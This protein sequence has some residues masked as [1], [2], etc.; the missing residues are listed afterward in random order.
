MRRA[1]PR[2]NGRWRRFAASAA[3]F[4]SVG[5]SP[6]LAQSEQPGLPAL[7]K[8]DEITHDRDLDIVTATGNVEISQGERILRADSISF[9]RRA[10]LVSASGNVSLLEPSGDI[11]FADYI[12]LTDDLKEGIIQDFRAVLA[13]RTRLAAVSA[14]RAD[15][16]ITTARKVVYSPCELCKEDPSRAPLWQLKA[17]RVTHDQETRQITYGDAWM[18]IAGVP[19]FYTPYLS[20]PDGTVKRESGFLAPDIGT[21]SVLGQFTVIPY[22]YAISPSADVTVEPMFLTKDNPV[23]GGEYRQRTAHG[24]FSATASITN[25]KRRDDNNAEIPGNDVRGHLKGEGL[26]D[27]NDDWR[28]GFDVARATDDTYLQ[29]Y[30]L[31]NRY[32]FLDQN[33]LTSNVFAEA[34]RGRDYAAANAYAFQDL[35]PQDTS[36]LTPLVLPLLQYNAI[37]EPGPYGGRFSFDANALSI[38]RTEGT[39]TQ[40]TAVQGGWEIPYIASTGEIYT[41]SARLLGAAYH[42]ANAGQPGDTTVTSDG[43]PA[44]LFPQVSLGWRYPL[45]RSDG[46]FRTLIEPV[47]AIVAAPVLGDQ[48]RFPNEDSR[49]FDL[50]TTN[51]FRPN[52][53]TGIDRLE[54]GQRVNY[55]FNADI[56]RFTGGRAAVSIGQSYRLQEQAAFPTGSGLE[57]RFSDIVG[58]LYFS[59]HPWFATSYRFQLDKD[60]FEA[61]RSL[62]DLSLGPR[63][64]RASVSYTFL[65]RTTQTVQPFDIEQV[66]TV[67]S[68]NLTPYWRVQVRDVRSLSDDAGQ[69][70]GD[71]A[72]IYEDECLLAGVDFS[73]RRIGNRDNPPDDAIIFRVV[74]RN[75]GE[76]RARGL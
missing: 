13:D 15:G 55:G 63:A 74:F 40:R 48:S 46:T 43:T 73:R 20:H 34:F 71:V 47:A 51:L 41:L 9:N 76:I 6:A 37:G 4:V 33:T 17:A 26:F 39:R 2:K 18:E 62:V 53:F 45:V 3:L 42:V 8:A 29:R 16:R 7:L 35:R 61:Q 44:R 70:L 28:W 23:L 60:D 19:V 57:D 27:I 30:K 54:G 38:Y 21:S 66:S 52:R 56:A 10:N 68:A 75:L 58:R 1:R 31:F 67:V 22:F 69:L 5:L 49:G 12:E 25:A 24:R 36:G 65:D 32:R 64:L 59:P 14:R 11:V 50:D 72:L